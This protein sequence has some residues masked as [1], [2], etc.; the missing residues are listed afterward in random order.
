M[1]RRAVAFAAPV[2]DD[3]TLIDIACAG[4]L[5]TAWANIDIALPIEGKASSAKGAIGAG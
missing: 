3:V 1:N 4:Q 2:V 5:G